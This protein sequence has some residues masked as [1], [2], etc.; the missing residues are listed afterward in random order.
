MTT[1]ISADGTP[2]A[3]RR[4]GRGVPVVLIHGS[5]G[6]LDSWD[7]ITPFLTDTFEVW[8]YARRGYAPS[9]VPTRDKSFADDVADLRAIVAAANDRVHVVGASYGATVALH[10]ALENASDIRTLSVFEPPLFAAGATLRTVLAS[11]AKLL[12]AGEV[13]TAARLFAEKAAHVPA[14]MLEALPSTGDAAPRSEAIG[15]L[16]DLEAMAQ[17]HTDIARWRDIAVPT[18]LMQGTDSWQPI[19]STMQRLAMVLPAASRAVLDGQSHFA[20]HTAPEL[21]ADELLNFF[22]LHSA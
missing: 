6:G 19:P 11:Y 18:L 22:R 12:A 7:G 5:S 21:F 1:V 10:A 3:V 14:A 15:C 9:G 13:A 16:H 8:V 4:S 20:T 2:L 17:D